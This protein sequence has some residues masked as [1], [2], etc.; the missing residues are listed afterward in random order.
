MLSRMGLLKNAGARDAEKA[1]SLLSRIHEENPSHWPHGLTVGHFA[2]G[3]LW[4]IQ[5]NASEEPVGFFGWQPRT[6]TPYKVG[7]YSVG[8][9]PEYRNQGIA[10]DAISYLIEKK[11]SEVDMVR[12]LVVAGNV[13]SEKLADRLGVERQVF[14]QGS[15]P[16]LNFIGKLMARPGWSGVASRIGLPVAGGA[17]NAFAYDKFFPQNEES[18][19]FSGAR[20]TTNLINFA[21]GAMGMRSLGAMRAANPLKGQP[22]HLAPKMDGYLSK[23]D[24]AAFNAKKL[25]WATAEFGGAPILKVML[26]QRGVELEQNE[27]KMQQDK[28][29]QETLVNA[30]SGSKETAQQITQGVS[31]NPI[32]AALLIASGV[33]AA[34]WGINRAITNRKPQEMNMNMKEPGGRI[35]VTLPTTN[36]NDAETILDLPFDQQT[37]LTN[38][39]QQRLAIDTRR[40]LRSESKQRKTPRG[41]IFNT[42]VD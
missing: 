23:K 17:A 16:A 42:Q 30:L 14:K 27:R 35:R 21:S 2:P 40:R 10:S 36:E 41:Y 1:A 11:A 25:G 8:V 22:G 20:G 7:Y 26:G 39:M 3:N 6:E 34:G 15:L 32:L 24:L 29:L 18:S 13:A 28:T 4:L 19:A 31:S 37:V 5:K 12:A 38:P 9:L 33:G